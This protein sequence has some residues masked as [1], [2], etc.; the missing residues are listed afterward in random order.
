MEELR[1]V[2]LQH[3]LLPLRLGSVVV[4]LE[5]YRVLVL[6]MAA[7]G[8]LVVVVRS[9]T[10]AYR[11]THTPMRTYPPTDPYSHTHADMES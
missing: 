6:L 2:L 10:C 7:C 8:A 3:P 5:F 11:P 1:V 9:R 4:Q